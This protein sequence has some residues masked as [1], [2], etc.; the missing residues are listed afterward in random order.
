M[1]Q[2]TV[3]LCLYHITG[4]LLIPTPNSKLFSVTVEA[5]CV[6]SCTHTHSPSTTNGQDIEMYKNSGTFVV[7]CFSR[8]KT[9]KTLY[10]VMLIHGCYLIISAEKKGSKND[11]ADVEQNPHAGGR[12][13]EG[14]SLRT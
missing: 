5:E 1:F 7:V 10:L 13:R 3:A 2:I 11:S 14:K 4:P 8:P 6:G 9:Y 12:S